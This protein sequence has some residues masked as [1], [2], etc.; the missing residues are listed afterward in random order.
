MVRRDEVLAVRPDL[1][2]VWAEADRAFPVRVSRSWWARMD[3]TDP[4]DPLAL[5][6]LPDPRELLPDP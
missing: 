4:T 5:Q 2:P 3:P 6:V 1:G